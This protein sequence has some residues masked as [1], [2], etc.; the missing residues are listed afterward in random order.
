[1][2]QSGTGATSMKSLDSQSA[3]RAFLAH[4][5]ADGRKSV[6]LSRL[7]KRGCSPGRI[8]ACTV[9]YLTNPS[10]LDELTRAGE[11][12]MR[13]ILREAVR[14]GGPPEFRAAILAMQNRGDV[15]YDCRRK[16][17]A[18]CT[19]SIIWLEEYIRAITGRRPTAGELA[20]LVE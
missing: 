18:R 15:V 10:D 5:Q 16:G 9:R 13:R 7:A 4:C 19:E 6:L 1:M 11:K 8:F 2:P 17:V 12:A 3:Y 14:R 20:L